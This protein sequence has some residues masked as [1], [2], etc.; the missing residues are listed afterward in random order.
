MLSRYYTPLV[1]VV[2]AITI[3]TGCK[4]NFLEREPQTSINPKY[5][6]K[7]TAEIGRAHV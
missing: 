4:K 1:I 5:F 7:T 3:L 6:F 2:L